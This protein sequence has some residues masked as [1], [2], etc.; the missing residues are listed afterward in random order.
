M[1][2]PDTVSLTAAARAAETVEKV[3]P[4]TGEGGTGPVRSFE[5]RSRFFFDVLAE[6]K[7]RGLSI[8]FD[9]DMPIDAVVIDAE[10]EDP[11]ASEN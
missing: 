2:N 5:E 10:R 4:D 7:K 9:A 3:Y 8:G 6:M 11:G 1:D